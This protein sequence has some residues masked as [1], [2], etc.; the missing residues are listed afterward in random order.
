ME[1]MRKWDRDIQIA[2]ERLRNEGE[3]TKGV[4]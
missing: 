3:R 4:I 2:G 1:I